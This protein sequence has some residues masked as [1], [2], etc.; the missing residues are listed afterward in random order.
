MSKR[1]LKKLNKI[2]RESRAKS[3]ALT[4]LAIKARAALRKKKKSQFQKL[5][6]ELTWRLG[7]K[8]GRIQS[9]LINGRT[10]SP[11]DPKNHTLMT[12][13]LLDYAEEFDHYIKYK[14]VEK[15]VRT[16]RPKQGH[17]LSYANKV[18]YYYFLKNLEVWLLIHDPRCK[19]IKI[20]RAQKTKYFKQR[21]FLNE[22]SLRRM[23]KEAF[24]LLPYSQRT[25]C[26]L[27]YLRI[28]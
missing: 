25:I 17:F 22:S 13:D 3:K 26:D 8:F 24:Q 21:M 14:I 1:P 18:I 23:M 20:G 4:A 2:L 11:I 28:L 16:Y 9:K 6:Y 27:R 15:V 7:P 5:I 10:Q 12:V 19:P